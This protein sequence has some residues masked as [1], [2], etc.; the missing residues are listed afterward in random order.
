[1]TLLETY[2]NSRS[3]VS[4]PTSVY[5]P[6]LAFPIPSKTS[7]SMEIDTSPKPSDLKAL[8]ELTESKADVEKGGVLPP[9]VAA[10]ATVDVVNSKNPANP[11]FAHTTLQVYPYSLFLQKEYCSS[12]QATATPEAMSEVVSTLLSPSPLPPTMDAA[13]P[14]SLSSLLAAVLRAVN[15]LTLN[16]SY[17][18]SPKPV[19]TLPPIWFAFCDYDSTSTDTNSL[20]SNYE[21]VTA[22]ASLIRT[23]RISLLSNIPS[24]SPELQQQLFGAYICTI[25]KFLLCSEGSNPYSFA[26]YFSSSK[27]RLHVLK[28][29]LEDERDNLFQD[30]FKDNAMFRSVL[31]KIEER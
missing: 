16:S 8:I 27:S 30:S 29:E 3:D 24:A 28:K 26:G 4:T 13:S 15:S 19:L 31:S 22:V 25:N 18:S 2:L 11:N 14:C 20:S 5:Y 21:T 10:M 9:L 17:P 1:M 6:S 12:V 7:E 23:F